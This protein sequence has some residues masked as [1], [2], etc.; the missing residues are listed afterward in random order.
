MTWYNIRGIAMALAV[1]LGLRIFGVGGGLRVAAVMRRATT[2]LCV[3]LVAGI[4]SANAYGS[5]GMAGKPGEDRMAQAGA[6]RASTGKGKTSDAS[7]HSSGGMQTGASSS[8]PANT[9]RDKSFSSKP[10]D[11][12]S[13]GTASL[14][15]GTTTQQA[16]TPGAVPN[17]P[18]ANTAAV[19]DQLSNAIPGVGLSNSVYKAGKLVAGEDTTFGPLGDALGADTGVQSGWQP[20]RTRGMDGGPQ[21]DGQPS[22]APASRAIVG[23]DSAT[24][25]SDAL[26]GGGDFS[27]VSLQDVPEQLRRRKAMAGSSMMSAGAMTATGL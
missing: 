20:D 3:W 26:L 5:D 2:L 16:Y 14:G 25:G 13:L 23:D 9:V 19:V 18:D 4:V 22:L 12:S 24:P 10:S 21:N 6:G 17:F 8:T 7:G 11:R 15:G 27:D 1:P